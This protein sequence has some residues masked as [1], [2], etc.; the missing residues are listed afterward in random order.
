MTNPVSSTLISGASHV[1]VAVALEDDP[2]IFMH[3]SCHQTFITHEIN[4]ECTIT[5]EVRG[6]KKDRR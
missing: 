3:S 5:R 1:I 2:R 4:V 6:M